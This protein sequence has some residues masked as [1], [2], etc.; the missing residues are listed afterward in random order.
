MRQIWH[1]L[2]IDHVD[3]LQ[4]KHDQWKDEVGRCMLRLEEE[5]ITISTGG[6]LH[7]TGISYLRRGP[8]PHYTPRINKEMRHERGRR[9]SVQF[10]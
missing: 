8:S 2:H 10:L 9:P 4:L 7:I 1:Y 6:S 5:K 3:S